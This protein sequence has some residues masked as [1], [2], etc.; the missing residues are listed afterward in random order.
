LS[1]FASIARMLCGNHLNY[2]RMIIQVSR[3]AVSSPSWLLL[4]FWHMV[5]FLSKVEENIVICQ[6]R[7]DQLFAKLKAEANNWSTSHWQKSW[8][9]AITK[10]N[11]CF[12]INHHSFDQLNVSD[13]SLPARGTDPPFSHK[14][15]VSIC[16]SRI[17]FA[18]K[19]LFVRSYWQFMWW[20]L[21]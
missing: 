18:A 7:A 14:S 11:N 13:H 20:A 4:V 6:W 12:I 2:I 1:I 15:V 10:F 9:F 5:D 19:H 17:L 21:S 8:Y 16:M 3:Q